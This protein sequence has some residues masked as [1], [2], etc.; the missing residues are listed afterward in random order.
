[1]ASLKIFHVNIR[2]LLP[3]INQLRDHIYDSCY[4]IVCITETWLNVDL[5]DDLLLI[6]NFTLY[7]QDRGGRGGGVAIY[8]RNNVKL[9]EIINNVVPDDSFEQL[10]VKIKFNDNCIAVGV[11]YRP[12]NKSS[13]V[14]ISSFERVTQDVLL[15]SDQIICCGDFNIDMLR[16][17]CLIAERLLNI[18]ESYNLVQHV[19]E[20]TRLCGDSMSL[21]DLF[22]CDST[23]DVESCD[24]LDNLN[25]E[26][27][28][29]A[30]L[31]SIKGCAEPERLKYIYARNIRNLNREAFIVDLQ[32][33][34]F[35][36]LFYINNLNQKVEFFNQLIIELFNT[37]APLVKYKLNRRRTRQP[38]LTDNIKLL[39]T[40]RQK[41]LQKYKKT[42]LKI[43]WDY[44]KQ[45]R[46]FTN[47]AIK[48]EKRAYLNIAL[49]NGANTRVLY[50]ELS[51]LNIYNPRK[52][53]VALPDNL[54]NL[55]ELNKHFIMASQ[56]NTAPDAETLSKLQLT[57]REGVGEF[58]FTPVDV[59]TVSIALKSIRSNA[60]G[61]DGIGLTMLCHCCP[62]VLI[63]ITHIINCA[64]EIN[65]FPTDWKV[66][67]VI[68]VPKNRKPSTFNDL[69]PISVLPLL[70]KLYEK[71]LYEQLRSH[72]D[73]YSIIPHEQSGFR[74]K[75][76]CASA[77]LTVVDDIIQA[78]DNAK[79]TALVLLDFTKAFDRI[80]HTMLLGMLH[81]IGLSNAS[82][83]LIRNYIMGRIQYVK[84]DNALSEALEVVNGVPQ[85]S[86]LGPLLF[87][88]YTSLFKDHIINCSSHFYADDT[89]LYYSFQES[90]SDAAVALIN[91]DLHS[92]FQIANKYCLMLNPTK[93]QVM[94][95]GN[96]N[97]RKRTLPSFKL[98]INGECLPVVDVVKNLGL[99]LDTELRFDKHISHVISKAFVQLKLIYAH[100]KVLL[101]KTKIILCDAL[102]L[103]HVNYCDVVY[104]PCLTRYNAQRLQRV[105]NACVRAIYGLS[106]RQSVTSRLGDVG[107]LPLYR[108][109]FLHY[110][111]LV[112]NLITGKVPIYLH[113]KLNFI[114]TSHNFGTRKILTASIPRH[115]TSLF[116]RS[117]SYVACKVVNLV[118]RLI[119]AYTLFN[120]KKRLKLLLFNDEIQV[121]FSV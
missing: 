31:L 101:M 38:W 88:I 25:I 37:H 84:Y 110:A 56:T 54:L 81:N 119:Q 57:V 120:F 72:V 1:M 102:V 115:R 35:S 41:A 74:S 29:F 69:R 78:T 45:L 105:Q 21:L 71:I 118:Y 103:S 91:A 108:R 18:L 23:I 70:S 12:P 104:G 82:L 114:H 111:S 36:N 83:T 43:H 100:F 116:T 96:K 86:I 106:K 8:I 3:K 117:F 68:P 89:Q 62:H 53:H 16:P 67:Y 30:T 33:A 44:Y 48:A 80:N 46:N 34:P 79:L 98:V 90:N 59:N 87:V 49:Q 51:N 64:I 107:W 93:S 13:N 52:K 22:I 32:S 24:I 63:Y 121:T 112:H 61:S 73:L 6:R 14:F 77:L 28:H 26:S 7:R 66:A 94:L 55:N 75:H 2:S 97:A 47:H 113:S 10:W 109:R 27:D 5:S 20:P 42:K 15:A 95:F 11:V 39:M 60:I 92:L 85:G 99:Y 76:S 4:D 19:K 65:A 58:T 50:K 40:L 9:I 17:N